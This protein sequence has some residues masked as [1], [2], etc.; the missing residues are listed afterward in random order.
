MGSVV[1]GL[2]HGLEHGLSSW[3]A[4]AQLPQGTWDLSS[5][6]KPELPALA[7]SMPNHWTTREVPLIFLY[8]TQFLVNFQKVHKTYL[9]LWNRC[10]RFLDNDISCFIYLSF[11]HFS[12][13]NTLAVKN[14]AATN[15][16]TFLKTHVH[17]C[18]QLSLI[19]ISRWNR[20]VIGNSVLTEE[21]PYRF[22]KW[23]H[24]FT[25]IPATYEISVH[26]WMYAF[27]PALLKYDWQS[28][29]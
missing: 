21:V 29:M 1:V 24:H 6:W 22:P 16:Y 28:Y 17:M 15:M 2:Q 25:F 20:W 13:S 27:F 18:F 14:I 8:L 10:I 23:V 7:G 9:I 3:G 4:G 5:G 26:F 11:G 12:C 19:Y